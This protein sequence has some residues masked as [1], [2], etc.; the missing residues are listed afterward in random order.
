MILVIFAGNL[1]SL[2]DLDDDKKKDL[3]IYNVSSLII[4]SV[5]IMMINFRFKIR[6]LILQ[7]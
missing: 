6:Y 2:A 4:A 7:P 1:L 3:F 5:F